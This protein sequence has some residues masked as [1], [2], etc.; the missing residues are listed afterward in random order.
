MPPLDAVPPHAVE[1]ENKNTENQNR[2]DIFSSHRRGGGGGERMEDKRQNQQ[3]VQRPS[4]MISCFQAGTMGAGGLAF[5]IVLQHFVGMRRGHGSTEYG[6]AS[7]Q[8][9]SV[10]PRLLKLLGKRRRVRNFQ[11]S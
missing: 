11:I 7:L 6:L 8:S 9:P 2:T 10:L 3:R 4:C 5:G 1:I